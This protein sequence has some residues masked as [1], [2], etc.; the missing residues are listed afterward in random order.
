MNLEYLL[1]LLLYS[2]KRFGDLE[3]GLIYKTPYEC[4]VEGNFKITK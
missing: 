2:R 1:G 4:F 3:Q